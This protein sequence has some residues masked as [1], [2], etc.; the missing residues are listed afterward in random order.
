MS[1]LERIKEIERSFGIEMKQSKETELLEYRIIINYCI[2][3]SILV[4]GQKH[5]N[6]L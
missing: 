1:D 5:I 3:F 6:T 2:G 4:S